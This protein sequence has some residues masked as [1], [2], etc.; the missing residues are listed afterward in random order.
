MSEFMGKGKCGGCKTLA[1]G[2]EGSISICGCGLYHV[3]V[4]ATT[5]HLTASQF[6]CAARL[7]KVGLGIVSAQ[8]LT[9]GKT[10]SYFS[11]NIEITS[12][13]NRIVCL[14]C[15]ESFELVFDQTEC[16]KS[17]IAQAYGFEMVQHKMEIL[18]Y[19]QWCRSKPL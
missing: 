1:E 10:D 5:L 19:C 7:F 4:N 11:S 15:G 6:E 13:P 8:E 12:E 9:T 3:R 2:P 17:D 16:L 14:Q 18:G